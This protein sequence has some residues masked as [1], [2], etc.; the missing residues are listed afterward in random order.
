M[1]ECSKGWGWDGLGGRWGVGAGGG[2]RKGFR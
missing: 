1:V 2:G